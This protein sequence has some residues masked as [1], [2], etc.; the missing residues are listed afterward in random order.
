M[1]QTVLIGLGGTGSRVV[2]NVAR[3]LQEKSININDGVVTC[4]VLDTNQADNELINQSGTNIPVIPTC[5][6][7][8][9][10]QYLKLYAGTDPLS[11]CPYSRAFGAES[12]ID[13]ASEMRV[14]SRIAFMDTMSTGKIFD[15][16]NAIEKVFHN[17]PGTPEKIR[18]M[19]V[20]SLSGGT[21]SGMFIQ[22]ALWLRKFFKGRNC[23]STIRGIFLLPD[24]FI[25]TVANIRN[26]SKKKLYHYANAYAAIRELNAINK[27]IKDKVQLEQPLIIQDLFD[28]RAPQA[29][30]VF[31][32]AFFIDDVDQKGAAFDSI[33][34][35]EEMVAQIV[36]MQLYAPMHSEL[37]SVE[38]NLF[39]AF[40]RS[41][42]PVYG[43]C[44]TA[45]AEYPS[46]T[47]ARYCA[48]RAAQD[49]IA[50]G[51]GKID[52]EIDALI[53]EEKNAEKDGAVILK[54][55]S[56]RDMF[57]KLFDERSQKTGEEI[58]QDDKLFVSIKKDV[59]D[60][61]REF[62]GNG[63]ETTE[64]LTCKIETFMNLLDE[65]IQKKVTECGGCEKVGQIGNKLPD[66]E[67][68]E[69]FYDGLV[70]E[71]QG[72]REKEKATVTK[73][74]KDFDENCKDYS[75]AII[76]AIVT[77]DMG[78]VNRNNEKSLFGLFQKKDPDGSD[79]FIHP[80]AAKYLLY[81]LAKA[82]EERQSRLA[83]NKRRSDAQT[84]DTK[85]VSFDNPKTRKKETLDE[86]WE[87]LGFFTSKSEIQHFIR[88]YKKFNTENKALCLQYEAEYLTQLVLKSLS[89]KVK[90]LIE[91]IE[92][93][94]KDFPKLDKKLSEEIE[95]NVKVNESGLSKVMYVYAKKDHK[96]EKYQSLGMDLMGRNDELY[97]EVIQAVYGKFCAAHRPNA[98]KNKQYVQKSIISVF[99]QMIV[100]SY[101]KLVK[102]AYREDIYLDIIQ[103]IRDEADYEYNHNKKPVDT[104]V[105]PFNNEL[106]EQRRAK[107]YHD[108]IIG[109]RDKLAHKAVPFLQAQPD[110]SLAVI[111]DIKG[112]SINED[113]EI[114]MTT[115]DGT[116]FQIQLQT[117]LTFWGFH[118]D[119]V[120]KFPSLEAALGTNKATAA[121][122][123]YGINELYC[124]SSIYGVK[125]EAVDKFNE[126]HGGDY[127]KY[128]SAVI[129]G[130]IQNNSEIDTPHIDKTW[131]EFLPYVSASRQEKAKQT[132]N[133]AF[134]RAIAY[135]RISLD[136]HGKYQIHEMIKDTYGTVRPNKRQL[137][138]S[139]RPIAETDISRLIK[140]LKVY[141][142]FELKIAKELDAYFEK[143]VEEMT[144]YI[145][146]E[147]IQGLLTDGDLNPV[148]MI[149][150]YALAKDTPAEDKNDL[151]GG[152]E[153]ALEDVASRYYKNRTPEEIG[154]AKVKLCH[155]IYEKSSMTKKN[156]V[157]E[158]WVK[159]FK[160]LKLIVD[161][162]QGDDG[163]GTEV[164]DI[165]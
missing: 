156:A 67:T 54:R 146:T 161:D 129:N 89:E 152:L 55:I 104:A 136:S 56:R 14:K 51:W 84:G 77:L 123:G 35:Y 79:Y 50:E 93:L 23:Q 97:K 124:Y 8:T 78:A 45:R 57:V 16:Q 60:E 22:V 138:Q 133:K 52:A 59:F 71:L 113:N 121:S 160:R 49:S 47:V 141:P 43:S 135:G 151:L 126:N 10:D 4:A 130:M 144:T 68:P 101:E 69:N 139:G 65:E 131:H 120:A 111:S 73:V 112:L 125:A 164:V 154:E 40:E 80:V 63:D 31:D 48:L 103:A 114:W 42:E 148:T 66:P 1:K 85:K 90:D 162:C 91:T 37:S 145:G 165:I 3:I 33:G 27:V 149:V 147:I 159:A 95:E 38:D 41:S 72:A 153:K 12:M 39:R 13:G 76:R 29:K 6:E 88:Q 81:K 83:V 18:V 107:R 64:I 2:N 128:Y 20:S 5:D 137:L 82:I 9:I 108:A 140:A 46:D 86:Y 143:D 110:A 157:L 36:Y 106:E 75:E 116:R 34:T 58:G 115:E 28:S 163:T 98:E 21:G 117:T 92:T 132:F 7:R 44:G 142:D 155:R 94:F 24:I 118:P 17:R 53:Q 96:E 109:Y 119:T 26:D 150:R 127:Y 99:H 15:L 105:D 100:A 70:E 32:N 61:S 11:W 19:V 87:Q 134:W 30:P 62:T 158:E 102:T 74:L 25:R 122:V